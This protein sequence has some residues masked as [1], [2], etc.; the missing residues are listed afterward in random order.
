MKYVLLEDSQIRP[1]F[2]NSKEQTDDTKDIELKTMRLSVWLILKLI[3]FCSGRK[4]GE[5]LNKNEM[6]YDLLI[7]LLSYSADLTGIFRIKKLMGERTGESKT[8]KS[9]FDSLAE[10]T[11][12]GL[13]NKFDGFMMQ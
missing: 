3:E 5:N 6:K 4:E 11:K 9:I 7:S 10:N 13:Y 2:P 12:S 8:C 1:I